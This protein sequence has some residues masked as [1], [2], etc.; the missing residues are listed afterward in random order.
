MGLERTYYFGTRPCIKDGQT[1]GLST[2]MFQMT[3]H[4]F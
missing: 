4:I 2:E 1:I 3:D